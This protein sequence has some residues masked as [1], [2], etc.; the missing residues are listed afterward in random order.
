MGNGASNITPSPGDNGDRDHVDET[1]TPPV[2][3]AGSH[4]VATKK[5][6]S[7][8][9]KNVNDTNTKQEVD[10][11][12]SSKQEAKTTVDD[13]LDE[14][15][16]PLKST[17][18]HNESEKS[19]TT[20][21]A[22]S[23]VLSE[24]SSV[25]EAQSSLDIVKPD[26]NDSIGNDQLTSNETI[27][28]NDDIKENAQESSV[29]PHTFDNCS[30]P[31]EA[32]PDN[33]NDDV[34]KN[35]DT[36]V[37]DDNKSERFKEID[38]SS[39]K[40]DQL[41]DNKTIIANENN[42][43][44]VKSNEKEHDC[45]AKTENVKQ[46]NNVNDEKTEGR[47]VQLSITEA[48]DKV[49]FTQF[50]TPKLLRNAQ[51]EFI[52]LNIDPVQSEYDIPLPFP[53]QS[54]K[55]EV[56]NL[57]QYNHLD[58]IA[59][60]S[61][62][63]LI[64]RKMEELIAY[65]TQDCQSEKEAVRAIFRW[66]VA[67]DITKLKDKP[68]PF[69]SPMEILL[70]VK[71]GDQ[72]YADLFNNIC[73]IVDIPCSKVH[74][75]LKG[76]DYKSEKDEREELRGTWSVVLIDGVWRFIDV[77]RASC[78]LER[79]E[80]EELE[81][82]KRTRT[83]LKQDISANTHQCNE[84][85]FFTDP[86]EFIYS[87]LPDDS[88]WQLLARPVAKREFEEMAFLQPDFFQLGMTIRSHPR[89]VLYANDG[90][91]S[92]KLGMD[93]NL[94]RKFK[95]RL[96]ISTDGIYSEEF[97]EYK[98]D[99]FVFMQCL[100]LT[101]K[102]NISFPGAGE[103]KLD[104]FGNECDSGIDDD[105]KPLCTYVIH[106]EEP[107]KNCDPY[108]VNNRIEWGPGMDTDILGLKATSHETGM[109]LVKD[110]AIEVTF[111]CE[112]ELNFV[113]E[114]TC[115]N[116]P[117]AVDLQRYVVH[118]SFDRIVTFYVRLPNAGMY[119]LNIFGKLA[120]KKGL[121]PSICTYL[122]SCDSISRYPHPYP[123]GISHGRIGPNA[124][125]S[126]LGLV[127]KTPNNPIIQVPHIGEAHVSF[128]LS[129]PMDVVTE[130]T[131]HGN[132][133]APAE[134]LNQFVFHESTMDD[135]TID[136]ILPY[137]G[138]YHLCVYA[139]EAS[140]DD[141]FPR[142]YSCI[143]QADIPKLN[144]VPFPKCLPGWSTDCELLE[145]RTGLLPSNERVH[146]A[147]RV[148]NTT[149]VVV[150]G[151]RNEWKHLTKGDDG[152]WSGELTTGEAGTT[153]KLSSC[154]NTE[155]KQYKGLLVY[156]IKTGADIEKI[157][158]NT[159][160]YVTNCP[161]E[162]QD[163]LE[164]AVL[165]QKKEEDK[166]LNRLR[167]IRDV[168]DSKDSAKDMTNNTSTVTVNHVE[169]SEDSKRRSAKV[170]SRDSDAKSKGTRHSR[171]SKHSKRSDLRGKES[172]KQKENHECK[173]SVHESNDKHTVIGITDEVAATK[174]KKDDADKEELIND[175]VENAQMISVIEDETDDESESQ[176]AIITVRKTDRLASTA[177]TIDAELI[178]KHDEH[179]QESATMSL[180]NDNTNITRDE[181]PIA[182]GSAGNAESDNDVTPREQT[183]VLNEDEV[184]DKRN[185]N[186]SEGDIC[187]ESKED[188]FA[189]KAK[190][191][192]HEESTGD[193]E[194]S[195]FIPDD[196]GSAT[197]DSQI[198][199][200]QQTDAPQS[201]K[202]DNTVHEMQK[203]KEIQSNPINNIDEADLEEE[204]LG[205]LK[206]KEWLE[207]QHLHPITNNNSI[208]SKEQK[209]PTTY[210]DSGM[211][212][213][214]E[215][216]N[217]T[218]TSRPRS[219]LRKI[220][221][222]EVGS[223]AATEKSQ[224]HV[225]FSEKLDQISQ[226]QDD[227]EKSRQLDELA[228][229]LAEEVKRDQESIVTDEDYLLGIYDYTDMRRIVARDRLV[230][231][232]KTG[233]V[234]KMAKA[235][236]DFKF[237]KCKDN[238][239]LIKKASEKINVVLLKEELVEA[240]YKRDRIGLIKALKRVNK[241]RPPELTLEVMHARRLL[242]HLGSI[243]NARKTIMNMDA[244]TISEIR[245]YSTP[246]PVVHIVMSSLLLVLGD[247]EGKTKSWK[248]CQKILS[249]VGAE[250]L[251]RRVG[252]MDVEELHPEIAMKVRVNLKQIDLR[253]VQNA[254]A[255]LVPFFIWMREM[256]DECLIR[257]KKGG[258]N[259]STLAPAVKLR[260]KE[261]FGELSEAERVSLYP[262]E[263]IMPFGSLPRRKTA[264]SRIPP[265]AEVNPLTI[266]A[267]NPAKRPDDICAHTEFR[268]EYNK[269][270]KTAPTRR[271]SQPVDAS[272]KS[273]A[274]E[275]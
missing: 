8:P 22:E 169:K 100:D 44:E 253:D 240:L 224:K 112:N 201:I 84:F 217:Q 215:H 152:I 189:I 14:K 231:A 120:N 2:V 264:V 64:G 239:G 20:D 154:M 254:S 219:S 210:E 88:T 193:H 61:P 41:D 35:S 236:N 95:Y 241:Y 138:Q 135:L 255:G 167:E 140:S 5:D 21:E 31:Y 93:R 143:I 252:N 115:S 205:K 156:E 96:C 27:V 141:G 126:S 222:D 213:K 73:R 52:G 49:R 274:P 53:P 262:E 266:N 38:R 164:V 111:S 187:K 272:G 148:S 36:V 170:S 206:V 242:E 265:N 81:S 10:L 146:F 203:V 149:D 180:E 83:P 250:G 42:D 79:T 220:P 230:A 25:L 155:T 118:Q 261:I 183:F 60:T 229:M 237:L 194:D 260:Q 124:D 153:L 248:K 223:V 270:L 168:R 24:P 119:G 3:A 225:A 218:V 107:S 40:S 26:I 67:Q 74:G 45:D 56:F 162:Q 63:Y 48:M 184:T 113:H 131:F 150:V 221:A 129:K 59:A 173:E 114:L 51:N 97:G 249:N 190:P 160:D 207:D 171:R 147:V 212:T 192:E 106:N 197:L 91:I 94:K 72:D 87:H 43:E 29:E 18:Q 78:Q 268:R 176:T 267:Y 244:A 19:S 98:L 142:V 65:I 23:N 105:F 50:P 151:A 30:E 71:H 269:R 200:V 9:K 108:P 127:T 132:N 122:L 62:K 161:S 110:G 247:H 263:L 158:D 89:C 11:K 159:N 32:N 227:D 209:I 34:C 275:S 177:D 251:S 6:S 191:A 116:Q 165:L 13:S 195:L 198:G 77:E 28:N 109:I 134:S 66:I 228:D 85:Y 104:I 243:E 139:K 128:G 137:Q 258:G 68:A 1:E 4:Q 54:R 214:T 163:L 46:L 136:G 39:I 178:E 125:F 196:D 211:A 179:L 15:I 121:V 92:I 273:Q 202:E 7:K 181:T 175:N 238:E 226:M 58:N 208:A 17:N 246:R 47:V 188:D 82:L 185:E 123:S 186:V 174:Q 37:E 133:D 101:F 144:A 182:E 259:K 145:P 235:L 256:V 55:D 257:Y 130:L 86:E 99:R 80:N 33:R 103:Y 232:L 117:P 271:K 216:T 102:C 172:S 57:A 245:R 69:D 166:K 204:E 233:N 90:E 75:F 199:P 70:D 16:A 12:V 234:E 157:K 76:R